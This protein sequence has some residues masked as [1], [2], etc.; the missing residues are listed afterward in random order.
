M[1]RFLF[2]LVLLLSVTTI[3]AQDTSKGEVK[4]GY[5]FPETSGARGEDAFAL[6]IG[7]L[8]GKYI[9]E[10]IYVQSGLLWTQN[11]WM[12]HNYPTKTSIDSHTLSIPLLG[13]YTLR[14]SDVAYIDFGVG[15]N[16]NYIIAGKYTHNDNETKFKDMDVDRTSLTVMAEIELC[17]HGLNVGVEGHF[18]EDSYEMWG[19]TFGIGF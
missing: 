11:S 5:F 16:L 6:S 18:G 14:F 19:V 2:L 4:I 12:Y 7:Y 3:S 15:P 17:I 1:K 13:G 9:A 10:D 8:S